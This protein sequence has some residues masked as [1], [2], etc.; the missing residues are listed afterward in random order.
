MAH[1]KKSSGGAIRYILLKGLGQSE[2]KAVDDALVRTA[3]E[4]SKKGLA[5][6]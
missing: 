5:S 3:I 1:D 6:A 2:L 4:A